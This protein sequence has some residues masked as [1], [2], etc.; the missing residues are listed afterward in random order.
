M[1]THTHTEHADGA[2]D[3]QAIA[4]IAAAI[5]P[6]PEGRDAAALA[7]ALA[8]ATDA[9]LMLFAVEP[10]LPLLVPGMN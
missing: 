6:Y 8:Q 3:Q 10:D 4:H 1:N 5:D 2:H 9:D 7:A